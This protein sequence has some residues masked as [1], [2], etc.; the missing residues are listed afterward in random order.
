MKQKVLSGGVLAGGSGARDRVKND[1]YATPKYATRQF[2]E[3]LEKDGEA[4]VGSILE[5]SCGGGHMSDVLIEFY[6]EENVTSSDI[7]DRGYIKQDFTANFLDADFDMYDNVITNPPFSLA[8]EFIKKSLSISTKKVIMFAKIQLLEG[9]KR[10]E[11]FQNTPL[12]YVYVNSSRVA[13]HRNGKE[14]D[15]NGK[16]WATTMCLAW[17]VWEHGYTGEPII[18]WLK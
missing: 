16:K 11:M 9:V 17:F 18:R 13:T 10:H 12:K 2:L 1:Y 8:S 4:L 15:E 3:Q 5:P 7:C 6:G 14:R